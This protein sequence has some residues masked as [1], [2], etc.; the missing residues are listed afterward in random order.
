MV[1]FHS[2]RCGNSVDVGTGQ[3]ISARRYTLIAA[4]AGLGFIVCGLITVFKILSYG[5]GTMSKDKLLVGLAVAVGA[6]MPD[7]PALVE[8]LE[9]HPVVARALCSA[10]LAV[11]TAYKLN[12]KVEVPK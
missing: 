3:R 8:L 12:A 11:A 7:L 6:I 1:V 2:G 9:L 4:I 5:P 10:L